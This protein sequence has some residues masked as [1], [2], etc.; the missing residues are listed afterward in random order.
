MSDSS[1]QNQDV[2]KLN[3]RR[4]YPLWC[5]QVKNEL[6][7]KQC[8]QAIR[9]DFEEPT[10]RTAVKILEREGRDAEECK[11]IKLISD[12]LRTEKALY[13]KAKGESIGIIQSRIHC[14]RLS[15]LEGHTTAQAMWR[16]IQA[17]FDVIRAS[18][19]G[20]IAAR[21]ISKSFLEFP[22]IEEYCRAYQEAYDEIASQLTNQNGYQHQD[23]AYEVLLQGAMLAKLP[24]SYA[25]FISAMD[26][27]W[28]DYTYAD[29]RNTI[30]KVTHY[31]KTD[32]LK[33]LHTVSNGKAANPNKRR[34]LDSTAISADSFSPI[35]KNPICLVKK[36]RHTLDK[37][38]ELHPELRPTP[39]RQQ[40]DSIGTKIKRGSDANYT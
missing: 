15:L 38:W 28:V 40:P 21:V 16:T 7:N 13:E 35:C 33:I 25:P 29:L 37:C 19:I 2:I 6:R 30:Q 32:P 14:S 11:D 39:R 4:D 1:K 18:D 8:E 23:K 34:R 31:L 27:N 36:T 3:D 10:K 20:S 12:K 17:E 26:E 5:V 24:E 9:F 22:S